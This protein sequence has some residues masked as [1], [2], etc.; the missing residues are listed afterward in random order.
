MRKEVRRRYLFVPKVVAQ[1][2]LVVRHHDDLGVAGVE[3]D[4][5][6]QRPL[7]SPPGELLAV[8]S[9]NDVA[10]D[11]E[12]HGIPNQVLRPKI[13]PVPVVVAPLS[14]VQLLRM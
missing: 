4:E 5:L 14:V 1:L 2:P 3:L 7:V 12:C 11:V 13:V 10:E 8:E 9:E 6:A